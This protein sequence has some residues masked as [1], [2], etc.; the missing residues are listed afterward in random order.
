MSVNKKILV[1]DDEPNICTLLKDSLTS[2]GFSVDTIQSFD[3]VEYAVRK[4]SYILVFLDVYLEGKSSFSLIESIKKFSPKTSVVVMTGQ[5]RMKLTIDAIKAGAYDYLSK[6]VDLDKINE[7]AEKISESCNAKEK[8]NKNI[9]HDGY[10]ADEIVGTSPAIE[11]I[12]K[13]IA[14]ISNSDISVLIRGESG[15]GKELAARAVHNNS[16]RKNYP[17]IAV[18]CASIPSSLLGSELFGHE[19]GS[20]TSAI[21]QKKGTFE[22]ANKGTIFLDEIGD[23]PM[24]MQAA[25]LRVLQEKE[26]YRIGA[27]KPNKVNVRII[28]ATNRPLEELMEKNL[29]REDLYYR[30]NEITLDLPSLRKRKGDIELLVNHFLNKFSKE[31]NVAPKTITKSAIDALKE[32]KWPGNIR[33]LENTIKYAFSVA[34]NNEITLDDIRDKINKDESPRNQFIEY[35][36][37]TIEGFINTEDNGHKGTLYKDIIKTVEHA[38]FSAVYQKTKYNQVLS[39]KILGINRNTFRTKL[40]EMGLEKKTSKEN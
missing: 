25:I 14:Y 38:L 27:E 21:N 1:V 31:M 9:P 7:I 15:T 36:F 30:L 10:E 3:Q 2:V 39:S 23:M 20:F 13:K 34:K 16:A 5:G 8:E 29:F 4:E 32:E 18:N 6:P 37:D 11:N 19:K 24:E 40:K 22:L 28:A 35:I 12:F 17:F 33:E 26:F